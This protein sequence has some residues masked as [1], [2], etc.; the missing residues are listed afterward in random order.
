[1]LSFFQKRD[2]EEN[3]AGM[4][5]GTRESVGIM[6]SRRTVIS[7]GEV[8]AVS[9]FPLVATAVPEDEVGKVM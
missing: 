6:V 7:K 3:G 4:V 2:E 5:G 8:T 1:M 9:L